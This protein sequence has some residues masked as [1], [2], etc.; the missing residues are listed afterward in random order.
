MEL[1]SGELSGESGTHVTQ[2]V[3][4]EEC[5]GFRWM[6]GSETDVGPSVVP[7]SRFDQGL[8]M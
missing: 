7:T 2:L 5:R 4:T 6:K 3:R 8:Q 1:E